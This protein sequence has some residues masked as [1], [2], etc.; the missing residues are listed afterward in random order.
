MIAGRKDN[1]PFDSQ[2][3]EAQRTQ[4][5]AEQEPEARPPRESADFAQEWESE[6]DGGLGTS[7]LPFY[8]AA[9]WRCAA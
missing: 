8:V 4:S 6:S 7:C 9:K 3:K 5:F 2:G 1:A